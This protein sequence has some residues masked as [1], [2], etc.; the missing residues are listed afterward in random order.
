ML[1][2]VWIFRTAS[3]WSAADNTRCK[4]SSR[5]RRTWIRL[6]RYIWAEFDV[7]NYINRSNYAHQALSVGIWDRVY[8]PFKWKK[9]DRCTIIELN[10][11]WAAIREAA[12]EVH[13][14][15]IETWKNT[16]RLPVWSQKHVEGCKLCTRKNSW[17]DKENE[18]CG[19][20]GKKSRVPKSR[21]W[22]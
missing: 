6:S 17:N 15:R 14:R 12:H 22:L 13:G 20:D 8:I 2:R 1:V 5:L 10:K 11:P 4:M 3:F 19:E 16:S 7:P 18:E 21:S 9:R